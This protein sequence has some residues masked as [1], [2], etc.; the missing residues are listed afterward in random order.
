MGLNSLV[1]GRGF[2]LGKFTSNFNSSATSGN[3]KKFKDP[4][5]KA[6]KEKA[7]VIQGGRFKSTEVLNRLERQEKL[8][9]EA[10]RDIGRVLKRLETTP[11]KDNEKISRI[12][13][14]DRALKAGKGEVKTPAK[15]RPEKKE[16]KVRINR[17][18]SEFNQEKVKD[19]RVS[20]AQNRLS[21][22]TGLAGSNPTPP[23]AVTPE[24]PPNS[25]NHE[26]ISLN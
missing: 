12:E 14:I 8:G 9:Y 2:T 16:I 11:V 24:A 13:I 26:R 19:N 6:V 1:G 7:S 23:K 4:I 17:E 18:D 5:L 22:A 25:N 20:A 3:L 21:G 10:K 15:D